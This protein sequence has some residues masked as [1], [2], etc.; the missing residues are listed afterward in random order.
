ML[1]SYGR[2]HE[3]NIFL[4]LNDYHHMLYHSRIHAYLYITLFILSD[5]VICIQYW[6]LEN[7]QVLYIRTSF[8]RMQKYMCQK[9]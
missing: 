5:N 2:I 1:I 7:V 6:E 3:E 4:A 9:L 8:E